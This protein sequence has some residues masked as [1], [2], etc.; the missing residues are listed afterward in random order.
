MLALG[1]RSAQVP[2]TWVNIWEDRAAA[3]CTPWQ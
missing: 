2:A 1:L 3:E